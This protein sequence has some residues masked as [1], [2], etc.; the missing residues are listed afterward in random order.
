[1][2]SI[3]FANNDNDNGRASSDHD[4]NRPPAIGRSLP[5]LPG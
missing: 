5:G 1:M 3:R 2:T 4:D